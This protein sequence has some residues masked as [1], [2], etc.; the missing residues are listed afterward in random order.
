MVG[1]CP[2]ELGP[3]GHHGATGLAAQRAAVMRL[4]AHAEC[5]FSVPQRARAV[6]EYGLCHVR[7]EVPHE[8]G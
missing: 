6:L 7:V 2:A 5:E 3:R 4:L 8:P 1:A